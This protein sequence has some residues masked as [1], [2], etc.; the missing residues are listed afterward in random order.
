MAKVF[1]IAESV[2]EL[3]Q[4]IAED[5]IRDLGE[6]VLSKNGMDW[7]VIH[8]DGDGIVIQ[9][10]RAYDYRPFAR[11]DKQHPWGWNNYMA[12]QIRKELNTEIIGVLFGDEEEL[13][14][15][16]QGMGRLFL[17][18][19]EEVGFKQTEDTFQYYHGKDEDAL[20][21]K[22]QLLDGDGDPTS[23]WLRSPYPSYASHVRYVH[24]DGSLGSDSAYNGYSAAAAC[25]IRKS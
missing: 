5:R 22:R 14:E 25:Y 9:M 11:P 21:R 20:D 8:K 3:K 17:M 7:K 6:T 4:M 23:W 24:S 10:C 1:T 19:E 13:I 2:A 15:D 18:S 12:S 16:W